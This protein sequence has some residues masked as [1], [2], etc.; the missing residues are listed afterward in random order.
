MNRIGFV[1][2]EWYH[3]YSRGVDG[4][5]TFED[6][7]DYR[8]FLELLYLSNATEAI[9][10]SAVTKKQNVLETPRSET[11]VSIGAYSLMPNHFHFVLYEKDEGGIS[12]FMQKL[13]VAYAMYFNTKNDRIGNL[14]VKPFRSKH[15][16]HD[17]YFQHCMNYVH[18]NPIELFESAWKQ[19]VVRDPALLE[20]RL[21]EYPYSSLRDFHVERKRPESVILGEE[22]HSLFRNRPIDEMLEEAREY[23][24]ENLKMLS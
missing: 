9:H 7:N 21:L 11:L 18:M 16:A 8:R 3:C 12:K 14:F 2:G 17:E 6:Q 20:T 15:L 19:G 1:P 10:R 4:R 5:I 23:H 24:L 13:G 22:I